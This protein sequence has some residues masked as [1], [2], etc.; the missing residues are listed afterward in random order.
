M[1]KYDIRLR[2][3]ALSKGQIERHKDF[4]GLYHKE[5]GEGRRGNGWFRILAIVLAALAIAAM[6]YA[7]AKRLQEKRTPVEQDDTDIFDEFKT[8]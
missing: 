6:M 8:E 4:K 1:T 5:P 2:R 7:G 3:K